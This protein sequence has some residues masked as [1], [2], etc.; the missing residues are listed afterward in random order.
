[1][2]LVGNLDEPVGLGEEC[3]CSPDVFGIFMFEFL[4]SKVGIEV[5]AVIY[6][7]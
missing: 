4:I 3:A 2:T 7:A 1:M 5:G 6:M